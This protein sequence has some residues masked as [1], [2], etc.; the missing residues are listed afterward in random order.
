[1]TTAAEK[2]LLVNP[3]V[4]VAINTRWDMLNPL[5]CAN[6]VAVFANAS[7]STFVGRGKF[8]PLS[9][10]TFTSVQYFLGRSVYMANSTANSAEGNGSH[11]FY[12]TKVDFIAN[13]VSVVTTAN[14]FGANISIN[15][16][17]PSGTDENTDWSLIANRRLLLGGRSSNTTMNFQVIDTTDSAITLRTPSSFTTAANLGIGGFGTFPFL[18]QTLYLSD[19]KLFLMWNEAVNTTAFDVR[20]CILTV[21]STGGVLANTSGNV[22]ISNASSGPMFNNLYMPVAAA[23]NSTSVFILGNLKTGGANSSYVTATI[24]GNTITLSAANSF[25]GRTFDASPP[26]QQNTTI[27]IYDQSPSSDVYRRDVAVR[28]YD[29]ATG[30]ASKVNNYNTAALFLSRTPIINN[31]VPTFLATCDVLTNV[32]S[33]FGGY[34]FLGPPYMPISTLTYD[35][36]SN[37]IV[38]NS[39]VFSILENAGSASASA[40]MAE[41]GGHTPIFPTAFGTLSPLSGTTRAVYFDAYGNNVQ[42]NNEIILSYRFVSA[43]VSSNTIAYNSGSQTWVAPAAGNVFLLCYGCGGYAGLGANGTA[44]WP[45]GGGSFSYKTLQVTNAQN[46][47]IVVGYKGSEGVPATNTTANTILCLPGGKGNSTAVG[48]GGN[49]SGGDFN[50]NGSSGVFGS[51]HIADKSNP[52]EY[53]TSVGG[54]CGS[55]GPPTGKYVSSKQI[56]GGVYTVGSGTNFMT[57][58]YG[59]NGY[60][61]VGFK[62]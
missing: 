40:N 54:F 21:N 10:N 52:E 1:M 42:T 7:A 58:P 30:I 53:D 9:K 4:G 39:S 49:A 43:N 24:S 60:V 46:I 12:L 8:Y 2:L 41:S 62:P 33:S 5:Y 48:V 20:A 19:N 47:S 56:Y 38:S 16:Y 45:G 18:P 11:F 32:F 55:P 26:Y 17:R 36:T 25:S 13:T 37:N 15:N 44:S 23:I 29:P 59:S 6:Q 28:K 22:L 50:A 34:G 57:S 14:A 31:E 51:Y 61:V 3:S 35:L 27:F